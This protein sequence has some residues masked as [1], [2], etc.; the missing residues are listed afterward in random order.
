MIDWLL[1]DGIWYT[2]GG[3]AVVFA[4]V[5]HWAMRHDLAAVDRAVNEAYDPLLA[6]LERIAAMPDDEPAA[7]APAK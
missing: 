4:I 1:N 5:N 7:T 6:E 2:V 3:L